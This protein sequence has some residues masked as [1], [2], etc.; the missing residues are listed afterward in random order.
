MTDAERTDT[1]GG[2]Y[3]TSATETFDRLDAV[4]R[5]L[6]E[7]V[8]RRAIE[9]HDTAAHG[10]DRIT[11]TTLEEIASE[12]GVAPEYV[13]RAL[14]EE[15]E[16]DRHPP[17][18]LRERILAPDRVTGGRVV[19]LGPQDTRA[20]IVTWMG[21]QEGLRPRARVADGVR[22][23]KDR[24]WSAQLRIGIGRSAGTGALRNIPSVV[25]RQ[26]EISD[27]EQLVELDAD[28]KIISQVAAGV[29]GGLAGAGLVGG[30]VTA[31]TVAGGSDIAQFLAPA[32]P[33]VFVGATTALIIAK[34]WMTAI[35]TGIERALDG[36][37]NPSLHVDVGRRR[38]GAGRRSGLSGVLQDIADTLDDLLR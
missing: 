38:R 3:N 9:L 18:S 19:R 25:H 5:P 24:H 28:T 31:V 4:S 17:R 10:P 21:G 35:R 7:R 6:A 20:S 34:S 27:E 26:T 15:L 1:R 11:R 12:L 23:E 37:S 30:V 32:A 29:G 13:R 16:I 14:A 36:I 2:G 22:W 33:A 8:L